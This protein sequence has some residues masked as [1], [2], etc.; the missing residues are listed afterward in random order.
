MSEE[1]VAAPAPVRDT[2]TAPPAV[3][4]TT[5]VGG[6]GP[7]APPADSPTGFELLDELGRGGMGVVLRARDVELNREVAVKVL[8]AHIPPGS[9][10]EARFWDE[11]RITGQLQHPGIPPVYRVGPHARRPAVHGHETDQGATPLSDLIAAKAL[12]ESG[13][14]PRVRGASARRSGTPTPAASCTGT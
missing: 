13:S 12:G 10:T 5:T 2:T 1:T 6:D 11:A 3:R 14:P 9:N 7:A 4:D 8:A